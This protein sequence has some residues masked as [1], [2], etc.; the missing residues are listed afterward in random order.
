MDPCL[1]IKQ[2]II[3]YIENVHCAIILMMSGSDLIFILFCVAISDLDG[4]GFPSI[5]IV[6]HSKMLWFRSDLY[7]MLHCV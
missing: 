5:S 3:P 1:C 2:W 7:I 4:I 6:T